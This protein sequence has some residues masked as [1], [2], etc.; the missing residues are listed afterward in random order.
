MWKKWKKKYT[1]WHQNLIIMLRE[2][3]LAK[4]IKKETRY[5]FLMPQTKIKRFTQNFIYT[6]S[7]DQSDILAHIFH[8]KFNYLKRLKNSIETSPY[9]E[10]SGLTFG[11]SHH[12]FLLQ[13]NDNCKLGEGNKCWSKKY[14]EF[15]KTKNRV[16]CM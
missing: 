8:K 16:V 4:N 14:P 10:W 11:G 13:K 3:W 9:F 6:K 15:I 1:F 2:D 7:R 5:C 12:F